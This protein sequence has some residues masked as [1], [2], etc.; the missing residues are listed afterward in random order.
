MAGRSCL[1]GRWRAPRRLGQV[2]MLIISTHAGRQVPRPDVWL[3]ITVRRSYV[4]TWWAVEQRWDVAPM[5]RMADAQVGALS[6][7]Q[8]WNAASVLRHY[9]ET[10]RQ[11]GHVD[12][13]N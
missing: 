5:T 13:W 6:V 3:L 11:G 10:R 12:R 9:T 4:F 2:D 8:C 1:Q 7:V